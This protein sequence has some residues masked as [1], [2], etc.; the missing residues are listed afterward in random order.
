MQENARGFPISLARARD[1]LSRVVG[2]QAVEVREPDGS[3]TVRRG[4]L[5][6]HVAAVNTAYVVAE[7]T[8]PERRGLRGLAK[9][10]RARRSLVSVWEALEKAARN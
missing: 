1:A 2:P 6:V 7:V 4:D 8:L 3:L 10:W 9:A 5:S